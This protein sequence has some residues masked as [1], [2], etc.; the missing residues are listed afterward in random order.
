M[1]EKG[2]I[3]RRDLAEFVLEARKA[4]STPTSA[5]GVNMMFAL[6]QSLLERETEPAETD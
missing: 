2:T 5:A 1:S 3:D 4:G 6:A